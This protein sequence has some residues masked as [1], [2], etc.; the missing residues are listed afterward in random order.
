MGGYFRF[1][2]NDQVPHQSTTT[3]LLKWLEII[4]CYQPRGP[5]NKYWLGSTE[6]TL[7]HPSLAN[8]TGQHATDTPLKISFP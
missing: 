6:Q 3:E 8:L 1:I 4:L 2:M 7:V 5:A